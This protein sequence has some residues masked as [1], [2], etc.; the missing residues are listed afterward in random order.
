MTELMRPFGTAP[1]SPFGGLPPV[2]GR[3][4]SLE[5][6]LARSR[7]DIQAAQELRYDVFYEEMGAVPTPAQKLSRRDADAFDSVCDH[8]L[9]YDAAAPDGQRPK[10]VG[11]YRLLR[12][13]VAERTGGFYSAQEF[14]IAPLIRRHPR[15][16]FLELGRSCVLKPWRTKKTVELLWRGILAYVLHHR[17]DVMFGCACLEGTDPS[18]IREELAFLRAHAGATGEW[19]AAA[20]PERAAP[21]D[22]MPDSKLDPRRALA[23]LPPLVKGY[24]RL[25]CRIGDGA[26]VDPQFGTTDVLIIMPVSAIDRRYIAYYGPDASRCAA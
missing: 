2:L 19:R 11:A 16:R 1:V 13:E 26:V 9:V 8:L 10:V 22:A 14:D 25:G 23:R 20:R 6:R 12:Q 18:A 15:L 5:V 21:M 17:I 24:L 7:H 3:L 4:G